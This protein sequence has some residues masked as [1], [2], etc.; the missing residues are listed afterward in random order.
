M[1]RKKK[2][3]RKREEKENNNQNVRVCV[4]IIGQRKRIVNNISKS[5]IYI[6]LCIS[7]A[8]PNFAFSL[9]LTIPIVIFEP[10][11]KT[12]SNEIV[13]SSSTKLLKEEILELTPRIDSIDIAI[14][15]KIIFS[16]SFYA[17]LPSSLLVF[18]IIPV[19]VYSISYWYMDGTQ[20]M[21]G[22][23]LNTAFT[24]ILATYLR[25]ELLKKNTL[26]MDSWDESE[27]ILQLE[28]LLLLK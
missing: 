17:S 28:K 13:G 20:L 5:L 9:D 11:S 14:I 2:K 12:S 27:K 26:K 23:N 1:K 22:P 25:L 19:W 3:K 18:S 6:S 7:A 10:L 15:N 16:P 8:Y 4:K 24:A 21:F